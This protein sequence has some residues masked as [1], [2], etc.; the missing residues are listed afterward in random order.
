MA[1]YKILSERE[2]KI[3]LAD[4]SDSF[5]ASQKAVKT[6]VDAKENTLTKGNLTEA[7]SSVLTISGGTGAI[8][9]SGTSIQ[10][11]QAGTSQDGYLSS[12]DWNTFNGKQAALGYT[13]ENNAN[14]V[15]S[16]SSSSTDTQYPS[17]KLLY[18][19]VGDIETLLANI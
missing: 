7:T 8:I 10:V 14:K 18:D 19:T 11:K 2:L 3:D 13:A 16:I 12:T 9:G 6:A 1:R 4:N 17:A 5:I 15:T